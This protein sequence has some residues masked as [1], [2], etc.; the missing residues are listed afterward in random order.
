MND[1][2]R[3]VIDAGHGG[4]DPGAIGNNFQEKDLTLEISKYMYDK[5]RDAGIPVTLIR[6]TDETISPTE[7]VK[8]VLEAYGNDPN[9]VVI[10]NHMNSG[11]PNSETAVGAEVIYALRNDEVL[12]KNIL[13]ELANEGQIIRKHYQRT[14]SSNPSK[15]YYFI[16]RDTGNTT[17]VLI[18]YGFISNK[19]DINRVAGNL[20]NYADAVVRAVLKTYNRNGVQNDDN[21]YTIKSGDSL[22]SIANKYGTNVSELKALNNMQNNMLTI[23]QTLKIPDNS[24]NEIYIVRPGDNLWEIARRFNTT[25][26]TLRAINNISSDNLSIGQKLIIPK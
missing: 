2:L 5:F 15:D 25:V 24:S 4:N 11:D 1:E 21:I 7:R 3:V 16:L 6:D 22:W 19:E 20:E 9:V 18:E 8:R 13:D 12:A 23:G 26:Q 17:P 14:L 10:S